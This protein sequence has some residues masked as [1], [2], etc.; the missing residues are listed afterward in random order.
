MA[1]AGEMDMETIHA[2]IGKDTEDS[3][4]DDIDGMPEK[5]LKIITPVS[6]SELHQN[7]QDQSVV[8]QTKKRRSQRPSTTKNNTE[9]LNQKI[10]ELELQKENYINIINVQNVNYAQLQKFFGAIIIQYLKVM[11]IPGFQ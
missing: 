4:N 1:I 6:A 5:K 10:Q 11:N 7:D 2:L 8:K 9:Q 3:E